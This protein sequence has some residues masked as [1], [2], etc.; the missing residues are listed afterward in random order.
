MKYFTL[1]FTIFLVACSNPYDDCVREKQSK[2]REKNPTADYAKSSST[3]EKFMKEC[4][5]LKK[6]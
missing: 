6:K 5:H 4:S 3:N 1:F 2:W